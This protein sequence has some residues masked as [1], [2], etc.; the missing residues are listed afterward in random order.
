MR[1]RGRGAA[2]AVTATMLLVGIAGGATGATAEKDSSNRGP[3]H[4]KS[5]LNGGTEFYVPEGNDASVQA[6]AFEAAGLVEEAALMRELAAQQETVW[7]TGGT[8]EEI[9][10]T[11]SETVAAAKAQHQVPVFSLYYVPGRDCSQ[12]SSG[13]AT[14]EAEYR[15]FVDAIADELG[16]TKA[17]VII[18]PDGVALLSSEPW[19]G[20]GSG[21]STG[22]PEDPEFVQQ[23]FREIRY[24]VTTLGAQPQTA[25]YIDA[26][27]SAWQGLDDYD[28]F[29]GDPNLQ[30]GI[31]NRLRMAGIDQATGFALNTSN[32]RA[33]EELIAYGERV[34]KCL[35]AVRNQPVPDIEAGYAPQVGTPCPPEEELD[36]MR[37]RKN[38]MT[39]FVLDTSRNGQGPWVLGD[40]ATDDDAA[41]FTAEYGYTT[42][43]P[44]IWCNPPQA[45]LGQ[46][47]STDTG[48]PLVDAFLWIKVPGQSDGRCTRG[49]AAADLPE[50]GFDVVRGMV[51]PV[52]GGWF[53]EQALELARL[54]EPALLP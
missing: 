34:S 20:Q 13:G 19:C 52:A 14:S 36:A 8:P 21:G 32:Y 11:V 33:T 12:Y 6:D 3:A 17:V 37:V 2:V 7:L 18:E 49:I 39:H 47:P 5:V 38:Q 42:A 22:T 16:S 35:Y 28:A 41:A 31:V 23:R 4:G 26:G 27:N 25:T 43:D 29:Y 44:E 48:H 10:A 9:G 46:R 45:G 54:A 53:V 1:R 24:A 40:P 15:A 51:D 50:P 30:Y